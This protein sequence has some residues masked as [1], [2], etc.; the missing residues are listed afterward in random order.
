VSAGPLE[1]AFTTALARVAS[2]AT[3]PADA[4]RILRLNQP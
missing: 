3:D 2:F 4:T 1:T